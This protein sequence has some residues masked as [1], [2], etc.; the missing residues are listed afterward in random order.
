[1]RHFSIC[2][3]LFILGFAWNANYADG[4]L[5][6]ILAKELE[7]EE[8]SIEGRV[9]GLPQGGETG[10]KFAFEINQMFLKGETKDQFPNQIYLSWQPAWRSY[11]NIPEVIPGQRWKLKVKQADIDEAKEGK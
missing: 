10:A 8:L 4:R 9:I 3:L 7:G 1:M 6:N 11:Q 5:Q 2:G